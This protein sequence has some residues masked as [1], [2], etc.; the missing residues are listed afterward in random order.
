M[1]QAKFC[2]ILQNFAKKCKLLI[3]FRQVLNDFNHGLHGFL[4]QRRKGTKKNRW[5]I[6]TRAP[7]DG[8]GLFGAGRAEATEFTEIL[9]F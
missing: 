8:N 7:N 6:A 1:I 3:S 2:N 9:F 4:P 5:I